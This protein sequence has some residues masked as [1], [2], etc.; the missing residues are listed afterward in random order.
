MAA[1]GNGEVVSPDTSAFLLEQMQPIASQRWGLGAI[2]ARAFKP[3]WVSAQT[4]T[5]QMGIVGNY[6]VA[7]VTAGDGPATIQSDG[8]Y[9]HA[10]QLDR[11]ARL[12]AE[13]IGA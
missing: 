3:G 2:G 11:L 7:I 5:R 4:E 1:L 10:W 6:A 13:R 12:L 8:D 9:A